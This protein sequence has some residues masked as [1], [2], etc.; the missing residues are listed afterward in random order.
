MALAPVRGHQGIATQESGAG[1]ALTRNL[2]P[3]RARGAKT[4]SG[5][6]CVDTN[7]PG[8]NWQQLQFA[9]QILEANLGL[10]DLTTK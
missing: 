3:K 7:A 4:D 8:G 9:I 10:T 2:S 6:S 1:T 5:A